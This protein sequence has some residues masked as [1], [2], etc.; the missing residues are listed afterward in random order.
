M[1]YI[2]NGTATFRLEGMF[3]LNIFLQP[4]NYVEKNKQTEIRNQ[5]GV[6][7][8]LLGPVSHQNYF[9]IAKDEDS[10]AGLQRIY[11]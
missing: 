10:P 9:G 5:V 3:G 2:Y 11:T 6:L 1:V 7:H 4:T 8:Y